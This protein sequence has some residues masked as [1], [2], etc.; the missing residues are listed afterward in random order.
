[1]ERW[2]LSACIYMSLNQFEA[3]FVD[4]ASCLLDCS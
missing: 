2:E 3:N 4:Y 1:M